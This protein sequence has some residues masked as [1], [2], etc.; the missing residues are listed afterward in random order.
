MT[1]TAS[2]VTGTATNAG[3]HT[4]T[5]TVTDTRTVTTVTTVTVV[6]RGLVSGHMTATTMTTGE[7]GAAKVAGHLPLAPPTGKTGGPAP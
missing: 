1:A 6:D 2:T 7:G 5:V 3:A 4:T